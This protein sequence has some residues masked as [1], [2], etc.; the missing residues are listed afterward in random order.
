MNW[1]FEK[2]I[3]HLRRRV[4][5]ALCA[6]SDEADSEAGSQPGLGREGGRER[7]GNEEG[8]REKCGHQHTVTAILVWI[9]LTQI[10]SEAG[11]IAPLVSG[12]DFP[13]V[14]TSL[15]LR[16]SCISSSVA[17]AVSS[18]CDWESAPG[19]TQPLPRVSA[20]QWARG[21]DSKVSLLLDGCCSCVTASGVV[22]EN[23]S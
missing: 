21:N 18:L 6:Y 15:P 14:F 10:Y 22:L 20:A 16:L 13:V 4:V 3:K 17:G 7:K 2:L 1:D 11:L 23:K 19:L 9:D 8:G 5:T 12:F